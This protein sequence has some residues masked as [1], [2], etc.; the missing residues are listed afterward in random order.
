MNDATLTLSV[1]SKTTRQELVFSFR[2]LI[3]AGWV[4]RDKVALQAHIDELAAHG[5]PAPSR[6]PIFMNFSLNL[7]TTS[8]AI[9]VVGQESSGEVEYI[10]FKSKNHIFIGIGS[11]HTDRGF[12]KFSIPASKQMYPKVVAPI[13]WPYQEIKDHWD[14]ICLRSWQ[15]RGGERVLYQEDTLASI[16]NVEELLE[17]I[18]KGDGLPTDDLIVFSG[19]IATKAGLVFG[20]RFD[21]EMEDPVL[22]RKIEHGY[23]IR[24]LPQY[25]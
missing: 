1:D 5:V 13:V 10:L 9:D 7:T 2:R 16:L 19:T 15:T 14:R 11:D 25:L 24:V 4:G 18:P 8:D 17:Q 6:T 20:E 23:K 12:E 3:C 22:K 21:I